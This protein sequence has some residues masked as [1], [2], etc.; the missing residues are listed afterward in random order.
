MACPSPAGRGRRARQLRGGTPPGLDHQRVA[1]ARHDVDQSIRIALQPRGDLAQRA[2]VAR[3]GVHVRHVEAQFLGD[4][5]VRKV[6][7]HEV[8]A[9]HPDPQRLVMP[10]QHR[11]G[12][13]V[14]AARTRLAPISLPV[15]LGLVKAIADYGTAAAGRAADTFR[16]AMLAHQGEALGIVDQRTRVDQIRGGHDATGSSRGR[17]AIPPHDIIT[18]RLSARNQAWVHHPGSDKSSKDYEQRPRSPRHGHPR[19]DPPHATP[20]RHPNRKRLPA[21]SFKN[22]I[23]ACCR[24]AGERYSGRRPPK[25]ASIAVINGIGYRP[26][27]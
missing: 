21:R 12:E 18:D 5:T 8:Q 10:G 9:Q 13:V 1:C 23:L 2:A 20:P 25:P 16:P 15:S 22:S 27:P 6:Q 7:T 24:F 17:F 3:H 4:L 26:P 11:A 14:K 19:H